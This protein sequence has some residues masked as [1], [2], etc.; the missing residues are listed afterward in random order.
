M[1]SDCTE[2]EKYIFKCVAGLIQLKI[3][4][5]VK[6]EWR[7][8]KTSLDCF[9]FPKVYFFSKFTGK[10][11]SFYIW[12]SVPCEYIH[13]YMPYTYTCASYILLFEKYHLWTCV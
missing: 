4:Y 13:T 2:T 11:F 7:F 8:F 1:V 5:F 6:V 10:T 12:P 9:N 3:E